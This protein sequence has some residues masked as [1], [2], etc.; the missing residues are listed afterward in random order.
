M[1]FD[2]PTIGPDT[3]ASMVEAGGAVLA[4][5]AGRS[6]I[7]DR[8]AMLEKANRHGIVIVSFKGPPGEGA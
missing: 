6:M 1:R 7:I 2:I 8:E 5:E 4:I 3:L